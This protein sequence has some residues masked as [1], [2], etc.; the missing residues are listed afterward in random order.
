MAE[1]PETLARRLDQ[2]E[3]AVAETNYQLSWLFDELL[4]EAPEN[5]KMGAEVMAYYGRN[6]KRHAKVFREMLEK[7]GISGEPIPAEELQA[8]MVCNGIR[9]ED[10]EFSQAIIKEREK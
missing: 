8:R 4:P 1:T 7:M 9:P 3:K 2:L 5:F 10:N 6:K